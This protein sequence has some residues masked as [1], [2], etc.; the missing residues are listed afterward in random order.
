M[1]KKWNPRTPATGNFTLKSPGACGGINKEKARH[2]AGVKACTILTWSL[3]G[4]VGLIVVVFLGLEFWDNCCLGRE[5]E[6]F[7]DSGFKAVFTEQEL[8]F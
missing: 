1:C 4:I 2:A 8:Q 7:L 6:E 5:R 3:A